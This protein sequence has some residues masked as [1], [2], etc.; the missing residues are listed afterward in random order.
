MI[1]EI[2][3]FVQKHKLFD[4]ENIFENSGIIFLINRINYQ[5][6]LLF[7]FQSTNSE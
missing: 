7:D 6:N 2:S 5:R 4:V 3:C 1:S